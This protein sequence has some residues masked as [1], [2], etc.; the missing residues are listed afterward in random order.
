MVCTFFGHRDSPDSIIPRLRSTIIDLIVNKDVS[1]FYVGNNGN[2][3]RMV[4]HI[5]LELSSEYDFKYYV[6]LSYFPKNIYPDHITIV[7]EGIE[8]V[9]PKF[10]INYRNNWMLTH[11]EYVVTYVVNNIGSGAAKYKEKAIVFNKY[12][13]EIR[14]D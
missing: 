3:D 11:S 1:L 14:K 8:S 7:P 5:L 2:F 12:V 9:Y 6:V 13:I 10:A 4:S